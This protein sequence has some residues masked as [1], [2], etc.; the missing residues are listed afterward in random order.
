MDDPQLLRYSRQILL[1]QVGIEG[2]QLLRQAQVL[3]IGM[4]GLGTPAAMYLTAAG[5]G[6]LTI[7]DFDNIDLSNLQRQILYHT[8]D[9]GKK[10]VLAAQ[11]HLSLLN[12]DVDII[13]LAQKLSEEDLHEQVKKADVVLDCTDNLTTRLMIN[14]ACVTLKTPLVSGAAIRMEGQISVFDTRQLHSPC[15]QCL[16]PNTENLTETC[17]ET[18]IFSPVVGII[19]SMQALEAMKLICHIGE[20]LIGK[21]LVFDALYAEWQ[22]IKLNKNPQCPVCA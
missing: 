16:Y 13:P 8:D 19:G 20:T 4:G 22:T 18:G 10:K 17:S 2:Q 15:Y 11:H 12:P 7:C 14:R 1:P 3:I 21:T 9:V 5:V 6:K